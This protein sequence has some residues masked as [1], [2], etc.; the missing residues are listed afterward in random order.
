MGNS[1]WFCYLSKNRLFCCIRGMIECSGCYG[2]KLFVA[3]S[4]RLDLPGC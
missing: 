1:G 4:F 2:I 3:V